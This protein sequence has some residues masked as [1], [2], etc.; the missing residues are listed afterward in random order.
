MVLVS[1]A[2]GIGANTASFNAV[3]G[4]LIR[5]SLRAGNPEILFEQPYYSANGRSYAIHP[6]GQRFLMIKEGDQT[7]GTIAE[8]QLVFV[9]N[10]LEALQARVPT[11]R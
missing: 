5:T 7:D 10:W 3:S 2:L 4:L 6:D 1:L 8:R 9:L 11:G